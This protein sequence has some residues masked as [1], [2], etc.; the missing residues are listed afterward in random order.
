MAIL[1]LFSTKA[2]TKLPREILEYEGEWVLISEDGTSILAHA[3]NLKD[4]VDRMEANGKKGSLMK[5]APAKGLMVPSG[6]AF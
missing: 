2:E 4:V 5:V 6:Y 1:N 3:R